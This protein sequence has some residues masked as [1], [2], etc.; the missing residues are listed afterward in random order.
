MEEI[1]QICYDSTSPN[2]DLQGSCDPSQ[3]ELKIDI[4]N[5]LV[6]FSV[7]NAKINVGQI[8]DALRIRD[9]ETKFNTISAIQTCPPK[10]VDGIIHLFVTKAECQVEVVNAEIKYPEIPSTSPPPLKSAASDSDTSTSSFPWWG[11]LGLI[12]LCL[13]VFGIFAFL[14][15]FYYKK[16]WSSK[17]TISPTEEPKPI[18][19]ISE[20]TKTIQTPSKTTRP[21]LNFTKF[22]PKIQQNLFQNCHNTQFHNV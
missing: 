6:K 12:I 2:S 8:C 13:I 3:C 18:T 21:D 16:R 20:P 1:I 11:I 9:T 14:G 22:E 19:V 15:F 7:V 5:T 10:I 17:K 4:D